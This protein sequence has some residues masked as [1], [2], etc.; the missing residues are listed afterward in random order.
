MQHTRT[1]Q[2]KPKRVVKQ[3]HGSSHGFLVLTL[4][5]LSIA[6]CYVPIQAVFSV[7]LFMPVDLTGTLYRVV[8]ICFYM[9]SLL[10][11][12]YFVVAIGDLRAEVV[13]IFRQFTSGLAR[14]IRST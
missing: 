7:V 2:A 12:V 13:G 1:A 11:P 10:D 14:N 5:T 4:L 8:T 6:I 9:E 3:Q